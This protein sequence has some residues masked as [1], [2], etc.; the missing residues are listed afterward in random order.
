M[1][2]TSSSPQVMM[3]ICRYL[4]MMIM[5]FFTDVSDKHDYIKDLISTTKSTLQTEIA[6]SCSTVKVLHR[7]IFIRIY[8]I[9]IPPGPLVLTLSVCLQLYKTE[10]FDLVT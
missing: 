8:Q 6:D 2:R 5:V 4:M 1:R 3:Y 10:I 9:Q 7:I